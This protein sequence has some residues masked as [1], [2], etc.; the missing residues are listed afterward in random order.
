MQH[1]SPRLVSTVYP[2]VL[3]F[4]NTHRMAFLDELPLD[5]L[6]A[7]VEWLSGKDWCRSLFYDLLPVASV[8]T[9]LRQSLLP[10][11]YRDLVFEFLSG[12]NDSTRHNASLARSAGCST[13]AQRVILFVDEYT[14]PEDVVRAV[15]NDADAGS[16]TKWPNLRSYAYTNGHELFEPENFSSCWSIIEQVEKGLPKLRQASPVTC[17]VSSG[18][19]LLA[20][21]P[22]SVSFLSQLT[23]LYLRCDDQ[24]IVANHLPQIFAPTLVDLALYGVNPEDIWNVFY[25]GHENQT[26]VFARLKRLVIEFENPLCWRQ[27]GA[28][29]LH[30]Q[31]A[32]NGALTKRSVWAAGAASGKPGCRVPLFPALRT[33]KCW[34]MTYGFHDFISHTQCH[35]SL[36]SLY[37][38]NGYVYF[39]FDAELFKNLEAVEFYADVWGSEEETTGSVDLY[40]SAFTSL[41][42]AKTNIQRMALRAIARDTIFQVPPDIGCANLR[43]LF[44]GVEIDFESMLRL[45]GSLKHLIE[46]EL[47]GDRRFTHMFDDGRVDAAEDVDEV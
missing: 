43:S 27:N 34:H 40:K 15:R 1:S 29:P 25:D 39:D 23:S 46:L 20:Y 16:E 19:P 35:N 8:S 7:V 18:I 47:S 3:T 38:D 26:V 33:L 6:L 42:H 41:L 2:C 17:D 12:R 11:L 36:V 21:S 30:L 45:L 32:T 24:G 13:Y 22:P 14:D 9:R 37:V 44:L 4:L 10:L 31:D 28:L 5:I